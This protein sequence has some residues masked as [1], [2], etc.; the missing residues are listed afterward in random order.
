MRNRLVH[1]YLDIDFDRLLATV[2]DD[3]PPLIHSPDSIVDNDGS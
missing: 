1:T 3:L 2:T